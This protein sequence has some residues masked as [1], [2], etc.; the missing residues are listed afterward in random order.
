ML[1]IM[2]TLYYYLLKDWSSK[3]KYI[4]CSFNFS[5]LFSISLIV[6]SY[7]VYYNYCCIL[8]GT[9]KRSPPVHL[10]DLVYRETF[11][12]CSVGGFGMETFFSSSIWGSGRCF[13]L[14]F[15]SFFYI[16]YQWD[17]SRMCQFDW[18]FLWFF[19]VTGITTT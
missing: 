11:F 3:V 9:L 7:Y 4:F 15:L 5:V 8:I 12:S 6:L 17:K 16:I 1:T 2:I 19:N 10:G 13:L 14:F 18:E